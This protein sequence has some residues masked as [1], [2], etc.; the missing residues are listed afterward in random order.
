MVTEELAELGYHVRRIRKLRGYTQ[1]HLAE[2][3]GCSREF[4]SQVETGKVSPSLATYLR[5]CRGLNWSPRSFL[6][7][8]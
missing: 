7:L 8:A 4:I 1:A 2:R 3:S 5:I 6:P